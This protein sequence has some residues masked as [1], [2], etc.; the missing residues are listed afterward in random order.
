MEILGFVQIK[1]TMTKKGIECFL[2]IVSA[3]VLNLSLQIQNWRAY[4]GSFTAPSERS[5][6]QRAYKSLLKI[7]VIIWINKFENLRN[8]TYSYEN[9]LKD[10]TIHKNYKVYNNKGGLLLCVCLNGSAGE[11]K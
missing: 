1:P 9:N 10:L 11:I 2:R 8:G 6:R 4:L 7:I 3:L 5:G